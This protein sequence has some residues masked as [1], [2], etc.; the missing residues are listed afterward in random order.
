MYNNIL[1]YNKNLG[2]LAMYGVG[3]KYYKN[4]KNARENLPARLSPYQQP[5]MYRTDK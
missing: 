4:L 3:K 2:E 5:L 1:D